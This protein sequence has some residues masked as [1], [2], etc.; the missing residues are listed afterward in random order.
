MPYIILNEQSGPVYPAFRADP[1][2]VEVM[3]AHLHTPLVS[4]VPW[5][6]QL[7][8]QVQIATKTNKQQRNSF[9]KNDIFVYVE[10]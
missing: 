10:L 7:F 5:P 9:M 3:S 1:H 6:L 4:H 8:G 2:P